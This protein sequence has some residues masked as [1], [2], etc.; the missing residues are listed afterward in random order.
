VEKNQYKLCL[1]V[2]RR[3]SRAGISEDI[4]LIGSWC[5]PFYRDYFAGIKYSPT[6]RTRDVDFLIPHPRRIRMDVNIPDLLKDLGFI[7]GHR[8]TEGYI[9]LEHPDL[10]IEFLS[11]ERGRGIDKPVS[12]PKLSVNAVALR[13]RLSRLSLQARSAAFAGLS[14]CVF[15]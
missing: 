2:L 8:G 11:P 9:Q 1:E 10:V 15:A 6:I 14:I 13:F 4:I 12:I 3:L 7:I 5:M